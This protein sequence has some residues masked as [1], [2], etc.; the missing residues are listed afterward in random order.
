MINLSI[1]NV[2]TEAK[3]NTIIAHNTYA[4]V[5]NNTIGCVTLLPRQLIKSEK[6]NMD[7]PLFYKKVNGD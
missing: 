7:S 1:N 3:L 5:A 6:N 2:K 4:I